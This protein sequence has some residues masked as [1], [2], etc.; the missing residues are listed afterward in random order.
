VVVVESGWCAKV[1]NFGKAIVFGGAFLLFIKC[2]KYH[3]THKNHDS[4]CLWRSLILVHKEPQ[5]P[6][7]APN[8]P[9]CTCF[10]LEGAYDCS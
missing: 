5:I 2:R 8:E 1:L 9:Y 10:C 6:F 4:P 7:K 3:M